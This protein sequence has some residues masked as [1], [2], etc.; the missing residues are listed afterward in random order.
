M[1]QLDSRSSVEALVVTRGG[2]V[3]AGNSGSSGSGC[4]A[5][6]GL[7]SRDPTRGKDHM[8]VEETPREALVEPAKFVPSVGT[9]RHDPISKSDLV[10]FVGRR[11]ACSVDGGE[12][13]SGCSNF[14]IP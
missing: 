4:D 8:V 14:G 12:S 6:S 7:P 2:L 13:D 1:R 3:G 10:E 11:R 9:S 5:Q